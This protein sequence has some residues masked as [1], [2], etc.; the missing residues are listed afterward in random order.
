MLNGFR[1]KKIYAEKGYMDVGITVQHRDSWQNVA[2]VL[3]S[4]ANFVT[5]CHEVQ[6]KL[7]M[8]YVAPTVPIELVDNRSGRDS[9]SSMIDHPRVE[10]SSIESKEADDH[11]NDEE[12]QFHQFRSMARKKYKIRVT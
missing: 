12:M 7:G 3:D 2:Q 4:K 9:I 5:Y 11:Q 10:S 1:V 8:T 6:K